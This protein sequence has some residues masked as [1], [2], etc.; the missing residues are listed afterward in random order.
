MSE[1]NRTQRLADAVLD[2]VKTKPVESVEEAHEKYVVLLHPADHKFMREMV[3]QLARE[4]TSKDQHKR[5]WIRGF[6]CGQSPAIPEGNPRLLLKEDAIGVIGEFAE[7][8]AGIEPR[9]S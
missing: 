4:R 5:L 3:W 1:K 7:S 9:L 2:Q 8:V 6:E